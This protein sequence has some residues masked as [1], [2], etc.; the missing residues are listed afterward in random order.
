MDE[1]TI[2]LGDLPQV[3]ELVR[4]NDELT[5]ECHRIIDAH[6]AALRRFHAVLVA[7]GAAARHV[8]HVASL[9]RLAE[10]WADIQVERL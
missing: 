8:E 5:R 10:A 1:H 6:A 4:R 3:Q 7:E 2:R 9:Q